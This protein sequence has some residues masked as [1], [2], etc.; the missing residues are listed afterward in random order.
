MAW[1]AAAR[2]FLVELRPQD[3]Y[4]LEGTPLRELARRFLATQSAAVTED[5][6]AALVSR[7]EAYYLKHQRFELYPG[8]ESLLDDLRQSGVATGIVTAG[9]PGR[10]RQ[11]VPAAFLD[12]FKALITA[13]GAQRGKPFPDPYLKGAEALGL[14]SRQCVVVENAPMGIRAAKSAG[15]YCVAIASTLEASFL[16]EADEIIPAFVKLGDVEVI[17]HLLGSKLSLK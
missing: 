11:C 3:Y 7:K 16:Q 2:E 14:E 10:I 13:D 9:L 17:R 8:V 15:S 12:R 4:P 6:V 1:Q 5:L